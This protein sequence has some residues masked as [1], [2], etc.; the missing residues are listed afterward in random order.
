MP[1]IK[2]VCSPSLVRYMHLKAVDKRR[3]KLR[4]DRRHEGLRQ[5]REVLHVEIHAAGA[6]DE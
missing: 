4:E 2:D 5:Q 6:A 1:K 3:A